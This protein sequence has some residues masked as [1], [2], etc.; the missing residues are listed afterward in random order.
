MTREEVKKGLV[1]F[2]KENKVEEL[3]DNTLRIKI[4]EGI[5]NK[6][7]YLESN[8][9]VFMSYIK[10]DYASMSQTITNAFLYSQIK[11]VAKIEN[12]IRFMLEDGTLISIEF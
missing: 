12:G 8:C 3:K 7:F 10:T 5:I 9:I 2:F 4:E 1:D 6:V 11:Q